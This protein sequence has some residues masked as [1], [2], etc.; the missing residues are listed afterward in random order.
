MNMVFPQ[1][2]SEDREVG[3]LIGDA[4]DERES[5]KWKYK[6]LGATTNK[7]HFFLSFSLNNLL[8]IC[9]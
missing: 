9:L 2:G 4:K 7:S 3:K 8:S 5:S 1:A 6:I